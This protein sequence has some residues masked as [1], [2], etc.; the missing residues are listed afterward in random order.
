MTL[1]DAQQAF[2]QSPNQST[3]LAYMDAA[4][5][6]YMALDT[7]AEIG[8]DAAHRTFSGRMREIRDWLTIPQVAA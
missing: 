4:I 8:S 6:R 2:R 1:S 3:A 5:A 7:V